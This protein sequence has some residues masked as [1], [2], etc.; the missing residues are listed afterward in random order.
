MAYEWRDTSVVNI[1]RHT[2]ARSEWLIRHMLR[3]LTKIIVVDT[4]SFRFY[5]FL[6]YFFAAKF[7]KNYEHINIKC[8]WIKI[9]V[10]SVSSQW[11][12]I[13]WAS[14]HSSI[15]NII[16]RFVPGPH[17]AWRHWG[18]YLGGTDDTIGNYLDTIYRYVWRKELIKTY[19]LHASEWIMNEG[20]RCIFLLVYSCRIPDPPYLIP[21]LY[22]WIKLL[23]IVSLDWDTL[24]N[25]AHECIWIIPGM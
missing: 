13:A 24:L 21:H 17:I 7:P 16:I 25:R 23:L 6:L 18:L 11:L 19:Y 5:F 10:L 4:D 12:I 20:C 3:H 1:L 22:W 15:N 14:H 2:I 9:S 8:D